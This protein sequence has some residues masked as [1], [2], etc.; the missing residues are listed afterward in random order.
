MS[1][2]YMMNIE[3]FGASDRLQFESTLNVMCAAIM[4][5]RAELEFLREY[6]FDVAFSEQIDLCG[7]GVTR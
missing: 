4:K 7:V 1:P 5:R 2:D 3:T 6:K